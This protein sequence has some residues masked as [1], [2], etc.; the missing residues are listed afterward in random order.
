MNKFTLVVNGTSYH[1]GIDKVKYIVSSEYSK[2]F[3]IKRCI[4]NSFSRVKPSEY[5]A[6]HDKELSLLINDK[7][8]TLKAENVFYLS[9]YFD[10]KNDMKLQTKSLLLRTFES[11]LEDNENVDEINTI[12]ILL[13]TLIQE[14][15][16][17]NT[18]YATTNELTNKSLSKMA[19]PTLMLD[20]FQ[21]TET[22]MDYEQRILYQLELVDKITK[23]Q[24]FDTGLIVIDL[25]EI[26]SDIIDRIN[27][28]DKVTII[29]LCNK[30]FEDTNCD[31]IYYIGKKLNLDLANEIDIKEKVQ[32]QI[33]I[34]LE[35]K[36]VISEMKSIATN[37]Q[38][39][40]TPYLL[41]V[42]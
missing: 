12:N 42:L 23:C 18:F 22:D 26:T 3:N 7:K 35:L 2:L 40:N 25:P 15:L 29:I 5:S 6:E 16:V 19:I 31:N 32:D 36:E 9:A 4:E 8:P 14:T 37:K 27:I 30:I 33:N 24:S 39:P 1:I 21:I 17:S 28:I 13:T 38:T 11:M 41:K 34:H 10:I 20:G